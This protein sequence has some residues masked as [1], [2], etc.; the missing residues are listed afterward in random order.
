[1]RITLGPGTYVVA[2]SG[3][4]D[5]MVLLDLLVKQYGSKVKSQ[6][7]KA[8]DLGI[9]T[10]VTRSFDLKHRFIVAH[11]DHGIR[12]DSA[13]DKELVQSLAKEHNLP[14]VF[15]KGHLGP[16]TSEAAARKARYEFLRQ[17]QKSSKAHAII[18]A[19]HQDDRL[20]TAVL[21]LLRGSGRRGLTSLKSTNQILRPLLGHSKQQ[22]REYA[23][24]HSLKWREDPSNDDTR[25]KRNHIRHNI[26]PR[27]SAGAKAQLLIL[28]EDL[29]VMNIELDQHVNNLL[30]TQP[31]MNILDRRWFI[32]LPHD[33]SKELAHAWLSRHKV[34]NLNKKTVERLVVSMKTAHS[35][36]CIDVDM[37]HV[38]QIKNASLA[39]MP[40]DR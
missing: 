2:V 23:V 30:H 7:S 12:P 17:V 11:F 8:R 14:F 16:K 26:M 5:S 40:I 24:N 19:H 29:E 4:V 34:R 25:Y 20:E 21:N 3:G 39:L 9:Q 22:L 38:L 28:L 31:A 10:L 27:F 36:R 37:S 6:K 13:A 18:T 15:K 32:L 35:G 33:I 1:M